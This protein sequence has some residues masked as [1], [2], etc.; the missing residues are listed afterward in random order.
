MGRREETSHTKDARWR[1]GG[2]NGDG[3]SKEE[4]QYDENA[5]L[6]A[7]AYSYIF[8]QPDRTKTLRG[9]KTMESE[10][11]DGSLGVKDLAIQYS[12]GRLSGTKPDT[13]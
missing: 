11:Q 12:A 6:Q 10:C 9:G 2:N 5:R 1:Q 13:A 8:L 4:E 3:R 7:R